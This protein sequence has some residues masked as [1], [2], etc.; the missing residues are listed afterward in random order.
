VEP[1][2]EYAIQLWSGTLDGGFWSEYEEWG[3]GRTTIFESSVDAEAR[4]VKLKKRFPN[5]TYRVAKRIRS[6]WE[7]A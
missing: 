1:V 4:I 7:P 5:A 2:T 6:D 3:D